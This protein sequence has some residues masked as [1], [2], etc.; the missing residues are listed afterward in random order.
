MAAMDVYPWMVAV[1]CVV[2]LG[3][4]G[5]DPLPGRSEF[6]IMR[7]VYM[8]KKTQGSAFKDLLDT[9]VLDAYFMNQVLIRYLETIENYDVLD[10]VPDSLDFNLDATRQFVGKSMELMATLREMLSY[11]IISM[12]DAGW[13]MFMDGNEEYA[14]LDSLRII[15]DIDYTLPP[16]PS[17]WIANGLPGRIHLGNES[18]FSED[19]FFLVAD[20]ADVGANPVELSCA[21]SLC[22]I[23]PKN[24]KCLPHGESFFFDQANRCRKFRFDPTCNMWMEY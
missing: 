14:P 4:G 9:Q 2:A 11:A 19:D 3:Q 23:C 17:V 18:R 12:T 7:D 5:C 10:Y 1:L 6:Q 22:R 13:D 8:D 16:G 24:R 21:R 20:I 15:E